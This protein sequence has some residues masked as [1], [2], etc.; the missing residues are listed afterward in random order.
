MWIASMIIY[1]GFYGL[2]AGLVNIVSLRG[3]LLKYLL[4]DCIVV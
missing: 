1:S 3:K 4:L 2:S